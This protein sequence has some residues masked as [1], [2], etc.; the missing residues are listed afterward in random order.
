M[1][2]G[3]TPALS[4]LR[5]PQA[6]CLT[7]GG[8]A[9]GGFLQY[10]QLLNPRN[11][12]SI[13]NTKGLLNMPGQNNCFLNSAVQVLWH[14]D[15]FRRSFRE[16]CGHACMEDSC[17]FCA[18]K[19]LF[20]QF[21]YS[22][23]SA[24]PPDALRRALAET[25]CDQRRFQ[26]G[27]MDDAAECFENILM[28]IHFHIANNESEDMCS[29]A[30]CI[31]HQKF[32]MTLVE[33]TVC[34][35]CGAT[36][37]PLPFTQM[38]HYV[39]SSALCSQAKL[40]KEKNEPM[41]N[42]SE[43][44]KRAGGLGDLRD[45]PS[46]CGAVIQIRKTLMNR[47]EIV[48]VGLVWDSERPTIDHIMD[49][50]K[51]IGMSLKLQDVFHSVVDSRWASTA[52][53]QLV[54]IVTYYGK[55]Y[56][57]FFFHTKLRVWI[58]FDDAAVREIGPKWEQVVEK[59]CKGH[60]QP[61][62]LL[63]ANPHGTP[64]NTSTAPRLV[65]VVPG[66]KK[67]INGQESCSLNLRHEKHS[68][69][70]QHHTDGNQRRA[71]TPNPEV[72]S[73]MNTNI[74]PRR[75]V[76]PSGDL[77]WWDENLKEQDNNTTATKASSNKDNSVTQT[78]GSYVNEAYQKLHCILR[79]ND[80]SCVP[81]GNMT[82]SNSSWKSRLSARLSV[83][84]CSFNPLASS[85]TSASSD[86]NGHLTSVGDILQS[87]T[88]GNENAF[89]GPSNPTLPSLDSPEH[90]IDGTYISRQTVENILQLQK[91]QR[92]RSM[93]M[94]IG[95]PFAGQRNSSSSLESLD[96]VF[97]MRDKGLPS[98]LN[99]KF[100][101]P[102]GA[103]V[104]RRRDSG[105]WSGDRNSASSSSTTSLDN[106]Y[107][108][109]VGNK[110]FPAGV[111]NVGRPGEAPFLTD[112]GY[113]SFSLSSS[114]SYPSAINNSPGKLDSRLGQIPENVQTAFIP[115]D[116]SQLQYC[117]KDLKN[118]EHFPFGFKDECDKLCAEADIFVAKSIERENVGDISMAALLSDTAAARARA[119]MDVPYTNSQALA[120]AK[121]KHSMCLIR[122][123]NLHKK[124][125]EAEVA[126]RRKQKEVAAD[127]SRKE[128]VTPTNNKSSLDNTHNF[129]KDGTENGSEE[130]AK[131]QKRSNSKHSEDQSSN[132][133]N[134]EIY[135]TLPKR[136]LKKK[137]ALSSFVESRT[138]DES[139]E[140]K[141]SKEK[142]KTLDENKKCALKKADVNCSLSD[143]DKSPKSPSNK[144]KS[145]SNKLVQ[146]KDSDL[147]DYSSEWE[148]TKKNSLYRTYSGP[149]SNAKSDLSD[150][151][152]SSA[153]TF[154]EHPAKKQHRIRRK[155][156]G[157]FMRRKN[158]SLPD[159]RE[160]QD[161]SG[162]TARSFDDCF[163]TQT[164]VSCRKR[165]ENNVSFTHS[166]KTIPH[167]DGSNSVSGKYVDSKSSKNISNRAHTPPPYKPPP[168]IAHSNL[169]TSPKKS[170]QHFNQDIKKPDMQHHHP[171]SPPH[172]EISIKQRIPHHALLSRDPKG[173]RKISVPSSPHNHPEV[174][175][176]S[177]VWLKELQLKQEEINRKRKL[178]EERERWISECKSG[179]DGNKVGPVNKVEAVR[180]IG[181][182]NQQISAVGKENHN[183]QSL[184]KSIQSNAKGNAP[185]SDTEQQ[186]SV[187]DLTSKFEKISFPPGSSDSIIEDKGNHFPSSV[188]PDIHLVHPIPD[189][190]V[191]S[192]QHKELESSKLPTSANHPYSSQSLEKSFKQP[193][194]S[195][196]SVV[197]D[198][199]DRSS[200]GVTV[201]TP[202]STQTTS[203]SVYNPHL[204]DAQLTN[205]LR[206]GGNRSS[207]RNSNTSTENSDDNLSCYPREMYVTHEARRPDKPPDY[208][209]AIQRLELLRNDR[210]FSKFYANNCMNFEA[211]LEQAKKRRGPKKSVTFSDKVVLVA[212]AGDEDNDF[213]PNP[214]L[215]R[216]YKQHLMQKPFS[217]VSTCQNQDFNQNSKTP[218]DLPVPETSTIPETKL[219]ENSKQHI[220]SPCHLCHK[221]TVESP[222]LY[223]PD[224]AYYMSRFQQK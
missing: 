155:L 25:F 13:T 166:E 53:H 137:G 112:P 141:N 62:L 107:F 92:Q 33:Q 116:I 204:T 12:M 210:S 61:L 214:L 77:T 44:L 111:R 83:P 209:T 95:N 163:F 54:G 52:T 67:N 153:Q 186:K 42:F 211:I 168:A 212:C 35:A 113:D 94:K 5:T 66:H 3:P 37:E 142:Q 184:P 194:C 72:S 110:K 208:E 203:G 41:P 32:A 220:Q 146:S 71:L 147:S 131:N 152:S 47:P 101:I 48:S 63:Y 27:F 84:N 21:Q 8:R 144:K 205:V 162:E 183:T 15:I 86:E 87:A 188:H 181:N 14:L 151:S 224:C 57:T 176:G 134:I 202:Y 158:R 138:G 82:D 121:M 22:Q 167:H 185:C 187:R 175:S 51:T 207:F 149:T 103:N 88:K 39:P 150:L 9:D 93:N 73:D 171:V 133:K 70:A 196:K 16:L 159:L 221:K 36:S 11:S 179:I 96:N 17:I 182:S 118:N 136:S 38:V 198:S 97:T 100:D 160:G 24:L 2:P 178:Q 195:T 55:H 145:H 80:H 128:S 123:S 7:V 169:S 59:C 90:S 105:N 29:A 46:S 191:L 193:D 43:L 69:M 148:Q 26:L 173:H 164:P 49:V 132:D 6:K 139:S 201:K 127:A 108:Y 58:Y 76:T 189:H 79:N 180:S 126:L 130:I 45:C 85:K 219:P 50:F 104:A 99:L 124:L 31:P 165:Q 20:A 19:E 216:V 156:M 81:N 170:M 177:A 18:L 34:H 98:H 125:K 119:A 23:E 199:K 135:A 172:Q 109:V 192:V 223:C 56:S 89:H 40:M 215:E 10:V 102:D 4:A 140:E 117:L 206:I 30:H 120:M 217:E 60:F 78:L 91:L 161:P 154:Q 222:K 74:Q 190:K 218:K 213:I 64:V 197:T 65:T 157:G 115:Y 129:S 122:S 143:N 114:D 68:R 174:S 1:S 28:R 75:A 200:C 106:P